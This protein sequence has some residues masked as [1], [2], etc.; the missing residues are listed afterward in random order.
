[1]YTVYKL[2][3][4][5]D[6]VLIRG[7]PVEYAELVENSND[8]I[9][10]VD[11]DGFLIYANRMW[12][13]TLGFN[14]EELP[15]LNLFNL[16][17]ESCHGAC[18]DRIRRLLAGEKIPRF[19]I[20]YKAR[21]GAKVITEGSLSLYLEN[22]EIKGIQGFFRDITQRRETEEALR[23]TEARLQTIFESS[24][25]GIAMLA[26]DG[27]FLQANPA[28][29]NFLGYSEDELLQLKI[30]D[31]T[32]P[33]DIEDTLRRRNIAG[34]NRSRS[35]ICEKR[36]LRKD[37]STLWTQLSSTWF[38]DSDGNP[39]YTV[40]VIQDIT[41]RKEAEEQIRELAYYDS[42]TKLPNR[43]L[44]QDRLDQAFA[45]AK[46]HN[47]SFALVFLDLDRFK[48]VND[49]LGH[50][51]GDTMLCQAA[52]RLKECL[53]GNDTVARLG[54]D[55]FVILLSDYREEDNLP[56]IATKMLKALA[57]PYDL[58]IREVFGTTSIGI[59]LYPIDGE[60]PADLFRCAD[61]AMYAA[62]NT[63]G[64]AFRFYS[65]EMNKQAVARMDL[66]GNLRRALDNGEFFLEYQPQ[67]D[68]MANKV[69][70]VE[71]LLRWQHPQL[72]IIPPAQFI[73]LAEETN[74]I[75]SLGEWVMQEV[76]EQGVRWEQEGYLPFR[77]AINVS[78]RQFAQ[79]DFVE[80]VKR[81]LKKTGVNPKLLEFEMTESV[82][83]N[84]V[85]ATVETLNAIRALG[86]NIA[87]DDFGTGYSS[88]SCL[89]HLPVN[90]LKIDRSFVAELQTNAE[91]R[92]I[93]E[94]TIAM[95][96]KLHLEV[97]AEGVETEGQYGFVQER[98]CDE[99]QGFYFSRPIAAQTFADKW[100]SKREGEVLVDKTAV[101]N[102]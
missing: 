73:P 67:V 81:L 39:I 36:Y 77:V 34:A 40:P 84:D 57:E 62:K 43:R 31:V 90:R 26:P 70:G 72:G 58:G 53:R 64:N 3:T 94:A 100:L 96:K 47:G 80:T 41:R 12:Q 66:E 69:V 75:L 74:L 51:I 29:C 45:Q 89:K 71:A 25:A 18:E 42:L 95:A 49:T 102:C 5:A 93:V 50:A 61:M 59:A 55:E 9:L 33:D 46:R 101:A 19:E 32:H 54:G 14:K 30:T 2:F 11:M 98:E 24:V 37:G 91:D 65:D 1:M 79:S 56:K 97:T 20:A 10:V 23:S 60:S 83:M 8:L 15:G 48:G 17:H 99:V 6:D 16:L 88:L 52:A 4:A 27:R 76:F 85:S 82:V 7:I 44:F 35:I 28:F 22:D 63:G 68:L 86:I 21:N 13:E 38:F 87:I 92:A 78:G